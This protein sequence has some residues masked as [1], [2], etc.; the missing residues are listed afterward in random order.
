[1]FAH[2]QRPEMCTRCAALPPRPGHRANRPGRLLRDLRGRRLEVLPV[3]VA[4]S[5]PP[6]PLDRHVHAPR[7]R[8]RHSVYV[9]VQDPA[10]RLTILATRFTSRG[11]H[12]S[13]SSP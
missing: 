6:D 5:R 10:W 9:V 13:R 3:A 12:S 8:I 2:Y 1:M 7:E 11:L 4:A